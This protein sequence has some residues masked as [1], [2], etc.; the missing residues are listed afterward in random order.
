M[1][2]IANNIVYNHQFF[3][4]HFARSSSGRHEILFLIIV[5]NCNDG[6]SIRSPYS[7][8]RLESGFSR[9]NG[10]KLPAQDRLCLLGRRAEDSFQPRTGRAIYNK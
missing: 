5:N 4:A 8:P 2:A 3:L 10:N 1:A 6:G 9:R 7:K